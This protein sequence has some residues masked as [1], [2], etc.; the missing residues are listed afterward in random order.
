VSTRCPSCFVALSDDVAAWV[1][2][3]SSCSEQ[4]DELASR[5]A[6]FEVAN[7]TIM[8]YSRPPNVKRWS[9]PTSVA[10]V[11]C[12]A[13]TSTRVCPY[14]HYGPLPDDWHAAGVTCIAMTGARDSGKSVYIA[15]VVQQL[16]LLGSRLGLT[17][18][19][20]NDETKMNF[21][22]YYGRP[23]LEDRGVLEASPDVHTVGSP[24][25]RPLIF[26]LGLIGGR[27]Q[28]VVLRDV[29]GEALERDSATS[30]LH[31]GFLANADCVLFMFDPVKVTTI[32][33][34]LH[35]LIPDQLKESGDPRVVLNNVLRLIGYG[36]PRLAVVLAKF[37][38]MELLRKV[39]GASWS[40]V[41]SNSGSAMLRDPSMTG[42]RYD[43]ADGGLL[44]EE[45][46]SLLLRLNAADV[47][48]ALERPTNGH[49]LR[50]RYFA[51][52]ALGESVRTEKLSSQGIKPFRC[53]DPVRW[54][55]S[56]AGVL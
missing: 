13:T 19:F 38:T 27:R 54:T 39:E 18:D 14:C 28:Y 49:N 20:G 55:L 40:R 26:S 12:N 36:N 4:P 47:V 2:T 5:L 37:D 29:A 3:S 43:E 8:K 7:R 52:S 48:N 17:V 15:V 31:L 42:S 25:R 32:K 45:I 44:N 35:D 51:I 41:M 23:L 16:Q 9:P 56:S 53:L 21:Q 10:C 34:L 33:D 50:Y 46:R 30:A 24:T 1:C 22:Q 11:A 6:G